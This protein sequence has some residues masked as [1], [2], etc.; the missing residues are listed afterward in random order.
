MTDNLTWQ[1]GARLTQI[2]IEKRVWWRQL[3]R[4][5][6]VCTAECGRRRHEIT[7]IDARRKK[8]VR[9]FVILARGSLSTKISFIQNIYQ[10]DL[11][12]FILLIR[13]VCDKQLVKLIYLHWLSPI[14]VRNDTDKIFITLSK[15]SQFS[16][17]QNMHLSMFTTYISTLGDFNFWTTQLK[18]RS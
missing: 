7:M 12:S 3:T 14:E 13:P 5:Q 10:G 18:S 16:R 1:K 6:L 17:Y 15:Q 9:L 4:Q 8:V 2:I 11:Y